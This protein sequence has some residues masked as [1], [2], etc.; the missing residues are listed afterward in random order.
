MKGLCRHFALALTLSLFTLGESAHAGDD[1][2]SRD[3]N[4]LPPEI[5]QALSDALG[6]TL[7]EN[8]TNSDSSGTQSSE[9]QKKACIEAGTSFCAIYCEFFHTEH[10]FGTCME[11]WGPFGG[12]VD[13]VRKYCKKAAKK[14]KDS[15][16]E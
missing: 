1:P 3:L 5:E 9:E 8:S 2:L 11:G 4:I 7:D 13:R 6:E 16:L 15:I 12:C 10:K 14:K